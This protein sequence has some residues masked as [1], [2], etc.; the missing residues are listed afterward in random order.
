MWTRAARPRA[1]KAKGEEQ[2]L[3]ACIFVRTPKQNHAGESPVT[4]QAHLIYHC[5]GTWIPIS[6]PKLSCWA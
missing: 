6:L 4:I 1:G 3:L 2:I 5:A